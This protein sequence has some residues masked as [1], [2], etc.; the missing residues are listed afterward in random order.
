MVNFTQLMINYYF[1][2]MIVM[3]MHFT[4]VI[5]LN[6]IMKMIKLKVVIKLQ[7]DQLNLMFNLVQMV[8]Q[9]RINLVMIVFVIIESKQVVISLRLEA[10][11]QVW[12]NL[13]ILLMLGFNQGMINLTQVII[14]QRIDQLMFM[15][16]FIQA[17]ILMMGLMVRKLKMYFKQVVILIEKLLKFSLVM[18]SS[19][20][21]IKL[22]VVI[23]LRIILVVMFIL[24]IMEYLEFNLY[25][26]INFI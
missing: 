25:F 14:T 12:I 17:I 24:I 3:V 23:L 7:F 22:G 16:N 19:R 13:V 10:N 18:I 21:V 5:K 15:F 2:S 26:I 20:K 8:K 11:Y 6:L 9:A 1:K 4:K